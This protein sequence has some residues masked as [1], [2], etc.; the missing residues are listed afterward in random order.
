M[1]KYYNWKYGEKNGLMPAL[2]FLGAA[3]GEAL[4]TREAHVPQEFTCA[5]LYT[6]TLVSISYLPYTQ[7]WR[8]LCRFPHV[9]CISY[10]LSNNK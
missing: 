5:V 10:A 3:S 2:V 4:E 8:G 6:A 7:E 1:F 9:F